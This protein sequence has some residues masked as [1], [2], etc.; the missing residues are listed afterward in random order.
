MVHGVISHSWTFFIQNTPWY[1]YQPIGLPTKT[2]SLEWTM[3]LHLPFFNMLLLSLS[4]SLSLSLNV[5]SYHPIKLIVGGGTTLKFSMFPCTNC[6]QTDISNP[7]GI[8]VFGTFGLTNL[9]KLITWH[10]LTLTTSSTPWIRLNL[11]NPGLTY[12]SHSLCHFLWH[13]HL[14]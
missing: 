1:Y 11:L 7:Q 4:L 13:L 12:I 14:F 3:L 2:I 8:N 9:S 10:H 5:M 6:F